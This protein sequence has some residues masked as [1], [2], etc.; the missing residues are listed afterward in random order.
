MT[1]LGWWE[2]FATTH[3]DQNSALEAALLRGVDVDEDT[4]APGGISLPRIQPAGEPGVKDVALDVTALT[5]GFAQL[6]LAANPR[7]W[8]ISHGASLIGRQTRSYLS[9]LRDLVPAVLAERRAPRIMLNA[10][11]PWSFGA[12]V[13]LA[14]HPIVADRPA[15]R[16]IALTLGAG[17]AETADWMASATGSEVLI[18]LHEP[19][20]P[21]LLAGLAGATRWDRLAPV[22][23]EHILGVWQ[24]LLGQ[25]P[26]GVGAVLHECPPELFRDIPQV[27]FDR[28]GVAAGHLFGEQSTSELK[29]AIGYS[30]GAGQGIGIC[31][32]RPTEPQGAA[33]IEDSAA[34]YAGAVQ[35]LWQQWSFPA[36][37]L[38]QQVDLCA[39]TPG[40][41]EVAVSPAVAATWSATARIAARNL[42]AG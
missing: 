32:P 38:V 20:V 22:D 31:L 17:L 37:R 40:L 41:D 26:E 14:G 36:E 3:P 10:A 4:G 23:P 13:E 42:A 16:E 28:V 25:L 29:D 21:Q 24:R 12:T 34:T 19:A 30:V 2:S 9:E 39:I 8:E 33:A 5:A 27:G 35:R 6:N 7:G 15:F 1:R 18:G 11:G